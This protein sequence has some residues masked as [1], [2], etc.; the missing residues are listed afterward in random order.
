MGFLACESHTPLATPRA[1]TTEGSQPNSSQNGIGLQGVQWTDKTKVNDP[2]K[3]PGQPDSDSQKKSKDTNKQNGKNQPSEAAEVI[4][5]ARVAPASGSLVSPQSSLPTFPYLK[6][7][8]MRPAISDI[9]GALYLTYGQKSFKLTPAVQ[10]SNTVLRHIDPFKA[11]NKTDPT[12]KHP[13]YVLFSNPE[14]TS[15]LEIRAQSEL[16]VFVDGYCT[17]EE[18]CGPERNREKI[19]L[20]L[21]EEQMWNRLKSPDSPTPNPWEDYFDKSY[22]VYT[23]T[24]KFSRYAENTPTNLWFSVESDKDYLNIGLPN[25]KTP[26][27]HFKIELGVDNV[28]PLTA[29]EG[30]FKYEIYRVGNVILGIIVEN[31]KPIWFFAVPKASSSHEVDAAQ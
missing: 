14:K 3:S 20:P 23:M 25:H 31:G 18:G 4:T 7:G 8:E 19:Y 5:S 22:L 2:S 29:E 24:E 30:K 17:P 12:D 16:G 28:Q 15:K 26:S 13:F 27:P 11:E 10:T 6:E 1:Q 21:Y 9:H